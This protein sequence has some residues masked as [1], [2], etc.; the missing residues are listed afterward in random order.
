MFHFFWAHRV[1]MANLNRV[2]SLAKAPLAI[3][4]VIQKLGFGL[5]PKPRG[6]TTVNRPPYPDI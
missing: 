2:S 3:P 1:D 6:S 5:R 4:N